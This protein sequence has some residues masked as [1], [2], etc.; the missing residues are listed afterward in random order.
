MNARPRPLSRIAL[1]W[2][3]LALCL[4]PAAAMAGPAA[5]PGGP[6]GAGRHHQ[7][8]AEDYFSLAWII[9]VALSPDGSQVVYAEMR[10]EPPEKTRNIDLWLVQ[11]ATG[12]RRRLTFD[13]AG[14]S[15]AQWSPDGRWIYFRSAR[16]QSGAKRP[17]LDGKAQVWRIRPDGT[18]LSAVTRVRKGV[19]AFQ[20]GAAGKQLYYVVSEEHVAEDVWKKLRTTHKKLTY[21]DGVEKM[22]QLW[23]LDLEQ[24]R[25]RKII[26]DKRV[27]GAFHVSA[28]GRRI[29]MKTTPS[30]KLIYNEG[31]SRM[32][33]WDRRT[34]SVTPLA[35]E[36]WRAKAPSPYG[37]LLE[38]RFS[39]DGKRLGFRI[40]FDGYPGETFVASFDDSGWVATQKLARK[41]EVHGEGGRLRWLPG[42]HDLC[43]LGDSQA[44]G[45][46]YCVRG[47]QDKAHGDTTIFTAA[48]QGDVATFD[49]G[50][51]GQ[52]V[53][54]LGD[55][56]HTPDVYIASRPGKT[57]TR[58][59]NVNPQVDSWKL[60]S[61]ERVRFKS[62]DGTDVEGILELP[63]G[64]KK[65]SGPLPFVLEIH[66][67]P[68][69]STKA[70]MRFWIYGRTLLPARGWALLSVNYRGSTGYGDTFLTELIGH[71]NHR[72][73]ADLL[74]GV[75]AMIDRG[76]ADPKRMAVMGWSNGG[77]L[78]NCLITHDQRFKAASSGAG[79]F[80]TVVQWM[81]ED[82]PGHVVN[83]NNGLPWTAGEAMRKSAPL[84]NAHKIK[85]PTLIHVG[86]NDH[87]T[88][89]VHSTGLYRALRFYLKVPSELVM[90][91]GE[92]HG[93]R[94]Y[95][96]R[97][98]KMAWDLA[99]FDYHVL[100][101]KGA[102][103]DKPAAA[104]VESAKPAKPAKPEE[105]APTT[106]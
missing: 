77:Y 56:S 58:L 100:G 12:K 73:V 17:P 1:R 41:W 39:D 48:E 7:I 42:S 35:D 15:G 26:D 91:P 66:G 6:Q 51:K 82:T 92:P 70:A 67:G 95:D 99:W 28:D 44:L 85:T 43:L 59:T 45:R 40:D 74:G 104:A 101:I 68:T 19:G 60:P 9:D 13:F 11:V 16:E 29:A 65:G 106:P 24:W 31:H 61:V 14:D 10:W 21:G 78:T 64:Y 22:S 103:P 47:V 52:M 32:D 76:I 88:P 80:D 38:P 33:V 62:R 86:S 5:A 94:E 79:I 46:V 63:P 3:A 18:D 50:G 27:I 81:A 102:R 87:R 89:A 23:C 97:K 37:W 8:V 30:N 75:D 98:A 25:E 90:Y 53:F 20:L 36:L 54:V 4:L 49:V 84:Y 96:H 72:D 93:L 2:A 83:F 55:Q 105:P 57:Y 71:K 34:N 69:A